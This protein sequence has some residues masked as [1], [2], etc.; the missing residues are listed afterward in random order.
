MT[1]LDLLNE[2]L[3][4]RDQKKIKTAN[5]LADAAFELALE[6]GLDGFV[7]NDLVK[8]AGYSRRTFANYYSCKEEAVVAVV[9][10]Y[11][12]AP[13]V[14]ELATELKDYETPI[15]IFYYLMKM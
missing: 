5:K 2:K 15:D 12:D 4:L 6:R 7:V 9:L 3:N 10:N 8:R 11:E 1:R 14:D 13:T